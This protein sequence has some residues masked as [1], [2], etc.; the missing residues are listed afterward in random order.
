[1]SAK[2]IRHPDREV[3]VEKL[4]YFRKTYFFD[5]PTAGKVSIM[6]DARYKLWVN[7]MFVSAGPCKGNRHLRYYDEVDLTPYLRDGENEFYAALLNLTSSDDMDV[8]EINVA[9]VWRSGDGYLYIKGT[10]D[11]KTGTHAIETDTTWSCAEETHLTFSTQFFVG[12]NEHVA[13]G[14]GSALTWISAAAS[15]M[16]PRVA[17]DTIP[18]GEILS[19]YARPRPIPHL[20]YR[21]REFGYHDGYYDAGELTCGYI[22]MQA[23]GKGNITVTYGE[24]FVKGDKDNFEKG[25]RTD[26]T[27]TLLGHD[28]TFEVD[29]NLNFESFWFR[30]FRYV[31]IA[32]TGDVE[33]VKFDYAE[34]GYPVE[35]AENYDFG[36][37]RNNALWEISARTLKRCMLETY[38]DCPYYEQLQYCM[39]T[40]SQ[41]LYTYMI[42]PD[43]RL[44][45]RAIDDFAATWRPGYLTEARAPSCKRQ[46]IP[47]FSL[48]FIYMINMYEARTEDTA[49]IRPYLPIVD[50]IL[51]YFDSVRNAAGQ[52]PASD[53]WDFVDWADVWR[54]DEGAPITCR[55]EGITVYTMMYAHAL[56]CAARLMRAVGRGAVAEEYLLR[57][58]EALDAVQMNCYDATRNLYADSEKKTQF[59]QHAQI[60]AVLT[61]LVK[62]EKARDLLRRSTTLDA[63]AGYA[64]AYLWFRALEKAECYEE[65]SGE[66]MERFYG[67]IDMHCSTIPETPYSYTRSECHAW[68]AV[69]L[70]EFTTMALGVKLVDNSPRILKISPRPQGT[71]HASGVVYTKWGRVDV[72]WEIKGDT[73]C[74]FVTNPDT[75]AAE[76]TAPLG[77]QNYEITLNGKRVP[78]HYIAKR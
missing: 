67:L 76:I 53:M 56:R 57:A 40:Y 21:P 38:V 34:T 47:G 63:Q 15:P 78:P 46:Y 20:Y 64:Y 5:A 45:K 39:D 74:L 65:L 2:F 49:G 61:G 77:Y 18:F 23:R 28:D 25:D 13:V 6:A 9:S 27:L 11:D 55:G 75:V 26:T 8:K 62:D 68:G 66:M 16:P 48:F 3:G 1:M 41:T 36:N 35:I 29:G 22:R 50:G 44:A 33:V 42:S 54:Q 32:C 31:K 72:K 51:G 19:S 7:G 73:F 30:T 59:S 71:D 17:G 43:T 70:Y 12:L 60:W 10:V 4:Y 37:D 52:I 58:D 24:C 14:Y 69:A